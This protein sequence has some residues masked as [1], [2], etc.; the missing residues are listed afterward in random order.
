MSPLAAVAATAM[1]FTS[2]A[3]GVAFVVGRLMGWP[4]VE[5]AGAWLTAPL[6][7]ALGLLS[8]VEAIGLVAAAFVRCAAA[9][10]GRMQR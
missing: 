1:V 2:T 5:R 7:L 3:G 9:V 8:L 6:W 10:R 4:G